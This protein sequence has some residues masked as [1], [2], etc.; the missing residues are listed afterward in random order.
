MPFKQK[1]PNASAT[2]GNY[3]DINETQNIFTNITNGS[4][5][6]VEHTI[7]CLITNNNSAKQHS[8]KQESL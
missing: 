1:G 2:F 6:F 7:L 8:E 3:N 4:F 5:S